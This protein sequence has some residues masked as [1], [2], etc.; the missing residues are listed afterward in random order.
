MSDKKSKLITSMFWSFGQSIGQQL[1]GIIVST[2]LAR[3]IAPEAY[4]IIAAATVFTSVATTFT[5]GGFGNALIQKKDSDDK[6][7]STMFWFNI[8]FSVSVYVIVFISAPLFVNV[9]SSS[10]DRKQLTIVMRLL[11][12]GIVLS[13]FNSFYRSILQKQLLFRKLFLLTLSGTVISACVGITLAYL[14]FGVWALVTQNLVS[15]AINSIFFVCFSKWKPQFYFSLKRLK[16][17][18]F[19]GVKMM[20]SGLMITVYAEFSSLAIGNRYTSE[21][22]AY[23]NK[24]INYPKL[25]ALNI[26]TSINTALFPIM[27]NIQDPKALKHLV[28]KFNRISAFVMTPMMLGLAALGQVFVELFLTEKWKAAIP[29]F[30]VCCINYAIQPIGMSSLQY[31]KAT[32]KA[33]EYLVLDI[34]RK[35]VGIVL[36]VGA[37][38]LNKGIIYIAISEVLSNFIAIFINMYPGKKHVG[39]RIREQVWDVLPKFLLSGVMFIATY[40]VGYLNASLI[41]KFFVQIAVGVAVYILGALVFRMKE[42]NELFSIIKKM[43]KRGE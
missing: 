21:D 15:Y 17:M 40:F 11:G 13:S 29:V 18:F 26:V 43:L 22:L 7:Y 4:G 23:Y 8:V 27:S 20:L 6:D 31:L 39:Y 42:F 38:I 33:T 9:F 19:Y 28:R 37:V 25:L 30:Q 35:A 24:G 16:P 36:L 32:G 5:S 2:V 34:I 12:I 1:V 41:V 14:G 3:L 10:F